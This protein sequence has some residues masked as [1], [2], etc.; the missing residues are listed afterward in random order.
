MHTKESNSSLTQSEQNEKQEESTNVYTDVYS[1][2]IADT[3][4]NMFGSLK[5]SSTS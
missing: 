4:R 1:T 5:F 3:N 2:K